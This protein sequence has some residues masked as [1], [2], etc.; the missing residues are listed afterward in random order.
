MTDSDSAKAW[1]ADVFD[2]A[3]PAYDRVGDA[4]HDY[5]GARLVDVAEIGPGATVLDVACGRGAVLLP[6]AAKTGPSGR[7]VGVDISS[8]MFD[9]AAEAISASGIRNSDARVMYAEELDFADDSFDAVVCA[10]GV[11]FFPAP[12]RAV[13]EFRRVLRPGG[14]VA[15]SSWT[16][17]DERWAWQD[18]LL[19]DLS[20][21]RRAIVRPFDKPSDLARLLT[22]AQLSDVAV[23]LE[24]RTISFATPDQ[25][26]QWLWSFSIR[27]VLEQ[28]DETT[29]AAFQRAAFARMA[30][31]QDS[32]GF[33]MELTASF[34][35]GRGPA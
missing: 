22:D 12:E 5:F 35:V 7:V 16:G 23:H 9:V 34:A 33:P 20:V 30:A 24:H 2:R 11:N 1:V 31:Q 21:P 6:A 4:Y 28:L 8:Q 32:D 10:F 14:V 26:W 17:E 19:A 13:A 27:G 29:R 15:L 25:W 18:E 3:A